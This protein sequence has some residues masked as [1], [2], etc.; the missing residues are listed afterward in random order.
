M[1]QWSQVHKNSQ[2]KKQKSEDPEQ[3]EEKQKEEVDEGRTEIEKIKLP[4]IP[5]GEDA[6]LTHDRVR[7]N[8]RIKLI[9]CL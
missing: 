4:Y 5:E 9:E 8:M 7:D 6:Y 2:L 1:K 3:K